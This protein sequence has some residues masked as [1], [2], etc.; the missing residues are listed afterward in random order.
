M[1]GERSDGAT[2]GRSSSGAPVRA[3]LGVVIEVFAYCDRERAPAVSV[4]E[5]VVVGLLLG[6]ER[7]ELGS[8]DLVVDAGNAIGARPASEASEAGGKREPLAAAARSILDV[9]A[10]LVALGLVPLE[11]S[12]DLEDATEEL[13]RAVETMWSARRRA[14]EDELGRGD[15]DGGES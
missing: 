7:A 2:G 10:R 15:R 8:A 9:A 4:R 13:R 6:D 11:G 1:T 14:L 3:D 12:P 5:R